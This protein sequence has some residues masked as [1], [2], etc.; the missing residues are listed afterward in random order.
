M[1]GER[2]EWI[3]GQG[4]LTW[5]IQPGD[6]GGHR[7]FRMP[8]TIGPAVVDANHVPYDIWMYLDDFAMAASEAAL[9]QYP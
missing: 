1:D 7:V 2:T 3:D 4:G 5:Q 8:T 9:P 6:I